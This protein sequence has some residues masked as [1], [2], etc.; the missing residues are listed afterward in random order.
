MVLDRTKKQCVN[1]WHDFLDPNVDRTIPLTGKWTADED[2]QLK[3]AF[4]RHDGKNWREIA[5][6]IPGRTT[7]QC[8]NRW[9]ESLNPSVDRTPLRAG[10]WS[11]DE[12][13]T[14]IDAVQ[15]HG[16]NNW[17]AIAALVPGRAAKS[18]MRRWHDA[19]VL[20]VAS[21]DR[22]PGRSGKLTSDE[23]DQLKDAVQRRGDNNN[24]I[25]VAALVPGR[26]KRQCT[27]RWQD[28]LG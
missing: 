28:V 15:R 9:H 6:M 19:L 4:Q 10:K 18:C 8:A 27:R 2:E 1:R 5:T 20:S 14:L 22:T 26:T 21:D 23:D 16:G 12:D 11:A 25:E 17:I 3:V 13:E 24:W 7:K